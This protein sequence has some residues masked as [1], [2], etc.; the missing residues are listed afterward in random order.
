MESRFVFKTGLGWIGISA[1]DSGLKRLTLPRD[2]YSEACRLI[3]LVG[4]SGRNPPSALAAIIDKVRLYLGGQQINFIEDVDLSCGTE[5]QCEVWEMNRRIPY[6]ETR[7]YS[8]I[9]E[10]IGKPKAARAVGSA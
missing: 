6:G 10:Q 7:S 1:S 4:E 3:G 2:S 5:F 9:A 8:W